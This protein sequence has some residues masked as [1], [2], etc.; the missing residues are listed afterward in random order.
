MST[1]QLARWQWVVLLI[2]LNGLGCIAA[3]RALDLR[4]DLGFF[5]AGL[6]VGLIEIGIVMKL[7]SRATSDE[8]K[9]NRVKLL[10]AVAVLASAVSFIVVN[11]ALALGYAAGSAWAAGYAA[12]RLRE[13]NA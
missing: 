12:R 7:E 1:R 2:G 4:E 11:H 9:W 8:T 5:I 13:G 3:L 10:V 6:A